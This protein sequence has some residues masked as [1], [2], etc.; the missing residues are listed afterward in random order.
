[1]SGGA[2]RVQQPLGEHEQ[3]RERQCRPDPAG[4]RHPAERVAVLAGERD[5]SDPD[6][7][8]HE[9]AER[10][11]RERLGEEERREHGEEDRRR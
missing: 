5:E 10:D 1:M 11:V 2:P 4:E 8:R 3:H 7:A 9:C 6:P